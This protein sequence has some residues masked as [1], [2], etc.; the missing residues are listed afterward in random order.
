MLLV[1]ACVGALSF[2]LWGPLALL[3]VLALAVL[4]ARATYGRTWRINAGADGLRV[5]SGRRRWF[6]RWDEV[7]NMQRLLSGDRTERSPWLVAGDVLLVDTAHG[8]FLF[9]ATADGGP[10]LARTLHEVLREHE[11]PILAKVPPELERG[12]SRMGPPEPEAEK[13]IGRES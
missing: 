11:P 9:D 2:F 12:L 7:R 3:M 5:R 6:S 10:E 8:W 4:C 1:L 13:G